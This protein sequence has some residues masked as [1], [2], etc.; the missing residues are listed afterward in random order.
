MANDEAERLAATR[1]AL[2]RLL[3]GATPPSRDDLRAA[4]T[5]VDAA[6]TRV[7]AAERLPA[8]V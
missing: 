1:A 4:A 3:Y 7:L 2:E 6:A 8:P 5:A